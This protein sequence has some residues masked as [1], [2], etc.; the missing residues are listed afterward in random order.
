[1]NSSD[2]F[3]HLGK[4]AIIG[5]VGRFPGANDIE[6][7]WQNLRDGVES[8]SV[9]TDEELRASGVD[10]AVLSDPN[11]VKAGAV[12]EDV[13]LFDA[14]FFGFSPRGA[15]ILDPQHRVFLECAWEALESAGY[16]SE[17]YEGLIGV[18]AGVGMNTYLL[19]NL[20]PNRS[21]VESVGNYQIMISND[22]DYVPTR[23][24]YLLNLKGPSVN[25]QSAC[26][27]SLVAVHVACQSLLNGECDMALAG[28]TTIY[29]PQK[30][31]YLYREG[32]IRSPDGHCRAFDARA[33]GMVAG[34]GV[35]IVVLK[36]LADALAD[37]D[38]IHAV[39]R[40]SAIN[41]DG[42]LK[43]GYTAPSVDGQAAVIAEALAIAGVA[44]ETVS[45]IEAHG[46]GTS[47]G[48]P[49]EVAALT[50]AFRAST[51][52]KGF[53]AIGS[54]KTNV[55]HL[56][57]AAGVT[58]L[59]KA[60]LALEHEM[61]PPSLHFEQPNPEIDF[62]NSPFFVN[63]R[64]SE[65]KV[66][67]APRRAGVSALGIGGTNAHVI[68]EEAP[69][70][71]TS[72]KSRPWQLLMLSAKTGSALEAMTSNLVEYLKQNPGC[73]L[74]DVAY[75]LQV[76]RRAFDCRRTVVC[77]DVDDAVSS[78]ETSEPERVLTHFQELMDRPLVF[79]FP[80]QGAQYVN[81]GLGLYQVEPVFTQQVDLCSELLEPHLGLDLRQVLYP[82]DEQVEEA[83]Q[84]LEQTSI[85]QPALFVIEY[86]LAQLWMAWGVHPQAMIG[87]SIGEYAAACLA[88]VFSL[89]EALALV[90]ARG[91]LMQSMPGGAM[92]AILLSE[93]EVQPLLSEHLSLATL[94]GPSL[95]AVSG[96]TDAID[97]LEQQ[98]AEKDVGYRRL[99]VSHAFH[100]EMMDPIIGPFT[101]RV[102]KVD[103]KPP[104]I[105]Y[106]SN[107]SGTWI[108]AA[109][110]TDPSYWARH[111][112][113]TV[114]FA[115]GA[116][117]LLKGQDQVLLEVGP[118][119]TLSTLVGQQTRKTAGR[120]V[121]TSL[122]HPRD[123][124]PDGAFLLR[125]LGQLWLTGMQVDWSG[126]YA[127]ESRR[128]VPLPTYPFERQ[129]YW[130]E[131]QKQAQLATAGV[132]ALHVASLQ[133]NASAVPTVSKPLEGTN[134]LQP[135]HL[136]PEMSSAYVAPRNEI[137]QTLADIWQELLGIGQIGIHDD[138]FELGGHSLLATQVTSRLRK[139]FDTNVPLTTIFERPTIEELA[140]ILGQQSG[141]SAW[142][143]LV[144][145]Q[146]EGSRP[147]FFC[148]H[149]HCGDVVGFGIWTPYL[150]PNQ[151]FYG[152]RARGLDGVQEP[153]TQI[154]AMAADYVEEIRAVQPEGPYY[155]G[156]YGSGS[157]VA[158]E[159]AQQL[160][161]QGHEVG[162]LAVTNW[163]P[164]RDYYRITWGPRFAF[165]FLRNLPY[166]L[167]VRLR[168]ELA[169]VVYHIQVQLRPS[170]TLGRL[171]Q[172]VK[173]PKTLHRTRERF[174]EH[175]RELINEHDLAL[176]DN[177][178]VPRDFDILQR[179][180]AETNRQAELNYVPQVYPGR[181]TL[182]RTPRQPLFCSFD[183]ELGWGKYAAGGVEIIEITGSTPGILKEPHARVFAERLKACLDEAQAHV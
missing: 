88:G 90:A 74:A 2:E 66:D 45:Y 129:R 63:T 159:M 179:S 94:N 19:N 181:I 136:R 43:V 106:V 24:S 1:M 49:V 148:A 71:K 110:A 135:A 50:R 182:F 175:G 154:E 12:L 76:G 157:V 171:L 10:S 78:L 89:E 127:H 28:G 15:E 91:Q 23:V 86:A 77:R 87:H 6:E 167:N 37:G 122:R 138:F 30:A 53:C 73:N 120:I 180:I 153:L 40:G 92:L 177:E 156:G 170:R 161:A 158:F 26:S 155:L 147:P 176:L 162:L 20:Y 114:R 39:I 80:G 58:G 128:R 82:S 107:V 131:A 169:R 21:L 178:G 61:I 121:L 109:E 95:C 139:T 123:Q 165:D 143:T 34:S 41:N 101:E 119:R 97:G 183:P 141:L 38:Y 100:S 33:Q 118:G 68:L 124:Q 13:E 99:H 46:T 117:E 137:E 18:Y 144:A 125:T 112:R 166:W 55:G 115:E 130:I 134:L 7:F 17:T 105:P 102:K 67:G 47:L 31:G 22:K 160:Q 14:S 75:T 29:C 96:P 145:L 103:L 174:E 108:T 140:G 5:M 132:E 9:F 83:G 98:L 113:Q 59:I 69:P 142:S 85:T 104:S 93:E 168:L 72:G 164:N 57:A 150:G 36:R 35:G 64:L 42:S 44:P 149:P 152:L 163:P 8:V 111:L 65:W 3:E 54:V 56:D 146:P 172:K 60:V 52:K 25:V 126:F 48:D 84:Q 151:P 32:M 70:L 62:A 4:V 81:M 173:L 116:Q 11:Y 51:E 133:D 16:D 79:M 27:T